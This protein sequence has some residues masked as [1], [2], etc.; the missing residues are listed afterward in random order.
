VSW[1]KVLALLLVLTGLLAPSFAGA[2]ELQ[3][4]YAALE[5][6]DQSN[7]QIFWRTPDVSGKPMAI[8][9]LLPSSCRPQTGPATVPK[10]GAWETGWIATCEGSLLGQ[11]LIISGLEATKTDVLVRFA[12]LDQ[13]PVSLRLTA[14]QPSLVLPKELGQ[15]E[16][17]STYAGLGFEHILEGW[18]HLLFLFALLLLVRN[19][20]RLVGAVTAFT[21]AHSLTLVASTM[22]WINLPAAPVEAVI[23][24]S[25]VFL[26]SEIV[27]IKPGTKRLSQS[28]P[29]LVTFAFGLLHGLGFAGALREI[30]LPQS[31][32]PLALFAFNV[33]VEAGQ[34]A[35]VIAAGLLFWLLSLPFG[36]QSV[37]GFRPIAVAMAYG[38]GGWSS[39]WLIERIASFV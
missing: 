34:L 21:V 6:I 35:F 7:W 15:W 3:P 29:W 5:Q 37:L 4:G 12:P 14:D 2:H 28:A 10:G 25:I 17:F 1:L 13:A 9:L 18:D 31:D 36:R 30:G 11:Q 20:W 24:L 39:Y 22:G 38:I 27:S 23:A 8:D 19:F 16:V 32:I 26:A 33:G